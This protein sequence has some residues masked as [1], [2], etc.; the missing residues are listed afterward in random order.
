MREF[1][2]GGDDNLVSKIDAPPCF[3]ASEGEADG[4]PKRL[5]A[6]GS[7]LVTSA[8]HTRSASESATAVES[9]QPRASPQGPAV[10][11]NQVYG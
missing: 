11:R 3:F 6:E 1:Q 10:G 2:D 7:C 4:Q 5:P 9:A 8:G